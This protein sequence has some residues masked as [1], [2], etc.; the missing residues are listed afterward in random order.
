MKG[1]VT[2]VDERDGSEIIEVGTHRFQCGGPD[3]DGYCYLHDSFSC[4]DNLTDEE[5][6]AL[7]DA[8]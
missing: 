7:R 4:M 6:Q 2:Y 1:R 5:R 3:G 8:E